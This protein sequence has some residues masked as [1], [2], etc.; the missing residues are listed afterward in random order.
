MN[1]IISA[2]RERVFTAWSGR[3]EKDFQ[4]VAGR[5][6]GGVAM[7]DTGVQKTVSPGGLHGRGE[8]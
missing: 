7:P 4:T 5:T 8:T 3:E 1:E 6:Q 2:L